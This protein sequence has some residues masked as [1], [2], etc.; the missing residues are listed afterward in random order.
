MSLHA[1]DSNWSGTGVVF[2]LLRR[3]RASTS[4]GEEGKDLLF[5]RLF[6]LWD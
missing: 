5:I 4:G 6:E 3:G 1:E 2:R